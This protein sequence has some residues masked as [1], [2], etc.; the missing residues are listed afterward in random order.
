MTLRNDRREM[1]L[2]FKMQVALMSS[3]PATRCI[4]S[5]ERH[6]TAIEESNVRDTGFSISGLALHAA[7]RPTI[8][9][10]RTIENVF[11]FVVAGVTGHRGSIFRK[12]LRKIPLR[13]N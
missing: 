12:I 2:H 1:T 3:G 6:N 4:I 5:Q 10:Q 11:V 9:C 7:H 13:E 8:F